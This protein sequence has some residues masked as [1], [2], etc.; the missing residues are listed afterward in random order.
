MAEVPPFEAARFGYADARCRHDQEAALSA[1][2]AMF[3]AAPQSM[4]GVIR[5]SVYAME[6]GRFR[7]ALRVLEQVNPS[8]SGNTGPAAA[9]YR[10]FLATDYHLLGHFDQELE[11]VGRPANWFQDDRYQA[12]AHLGSAFSG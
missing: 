8:W 11:S 5:F 7:E 4:Q 6:L 12:S 2:R 1:S 10:D 9:I 3:E